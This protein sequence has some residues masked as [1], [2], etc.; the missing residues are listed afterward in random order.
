VIAKTAA[1]AA[2]RPIPARI[3]RVLAFMQRIPPRGRWW[4]LVSK[5]PSCGRRIL[6]VVRWIVVAISTE[7]WTAVAAVA[8]CLLVVAAV[9]AACVGYRQLSEA[10][11]LREAQAQ[12]YVAVFA[13]LPRLGVMDLV[14]KNFGQTAARD[15]LVVFAPPIK[16]VAFARVENGADEITELKFP[17]LV[18]G[19]EWRTVWDTGMAREGRGDLPEHHD[20]RISFS[21]GHGRPLPSYEA[22]IDWN[23]VAGDVLETH[24]P[25]G[26]V[27]P[28][29]VVEHGRCQVV[30]RG[31]RADRV[32]CRRP[33]LSVPKHQVWRGGA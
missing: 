2:S 25:A 28:F 7:E 23:S 20:V 1:N 10:K 24:G 9:V 30:E 26:R 33:V 22:E 16:R 32:V 15:V 18:P 11:Q 21:D 6:V 29:G 12:P 3:T 13:K 17:T 4:C 19:Q 5:V 8:A 27:Q 14:V 31:V